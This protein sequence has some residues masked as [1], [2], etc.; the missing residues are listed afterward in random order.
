MYVIQLIRQ[1][2]RGEGSARVAYGSSEPVGLG[3][4]AHGDVRPRGVGGLLQH[5]RDSAG[6]CFFKDVPAL[7]Q[8]KD[9][10]D[11]GMLRWMVSKTSRDENAAAYH[12]R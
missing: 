1:P 3:Y 9:L 8:R 5:D 10:S 2:H 11:E 12:W 6:L 7:F 4:A